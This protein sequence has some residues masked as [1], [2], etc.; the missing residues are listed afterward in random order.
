MDVL[1]SGF[2]YVWT[3]RF[4][5][6][7]LRILFVFPFV[8]PALRAL[9]AVIER[10][11]NSRERPEKMSFPAHFLSQRKNPPHDA[12]VKKNPES[13]NNHELIMSSE[14][15]A[16]KKKCCQSVDQST[17]PNMPYGITIVI[18]SSDPQ[19]KAARD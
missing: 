6:W 14:Q 9:S 2:L 8:M 7:F 4:I 13:G 12:A 17:G 19:P 1:Q 15:T 11:K 3:L 10:D 5:L 16:E 18:P